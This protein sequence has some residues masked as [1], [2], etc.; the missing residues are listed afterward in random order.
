VSS[1]SSA[2]TWR[3]GLFHPAIRNITLALFVV[4]NVMNVIYYGTA[5]AADSL[6]L[7]TSHHWNVAIVAL[8]ELPAYVLTA[9]LMS[10]VGRKPLL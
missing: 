10:S 9:L 3:P 1:H 4:W 8:S 5:F 6:H 2:P 7:T